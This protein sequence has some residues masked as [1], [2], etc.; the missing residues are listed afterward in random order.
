MDTLGTKVCSKAAGG[1]QWALM[2][3][4]AV[5]ACVGGCSR[6]SDPSA[7]QAGRQTPSGLPVPRY[8][9]LKFD[10]VN[11]R[12]GPGD[13]YKLLWVY[14]VKGLPLQVVAET[15]EWRRVCD[16][17]G[18]MSWI[19][20]RTTDAQR[21]VLSTQAQDIPLRGRPSDAAGATATLVGHSIAALK[22][23]KD[24]WCQISV[25]HAKGWAPAGALWGAADAPQCH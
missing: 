11:A 7:P 6:H 23:C 17:T 18:A 21:T 20:R 2:L 15:E 1:G 10:K 25:G 24:G 13:D 4:I 3:A 14:N 22:A 5:A 8:I 9:S 12:S 19:H 16:Y